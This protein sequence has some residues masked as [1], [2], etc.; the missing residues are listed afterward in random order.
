VAAAAA[1]AEPTDH[2]APAEYRETLAALEAHRWKR[3]DAANSLGISRNTLWRR[4][5]RYGLTTSENA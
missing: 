1:S 5:R 4:L 2:D 3:A